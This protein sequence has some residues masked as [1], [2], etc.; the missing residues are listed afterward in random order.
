LPALRRAEQAGT[1]ILPAVQPAALDT[2]PLEAG[3]PPDS[4][5]EHTTLNLKPPEPRR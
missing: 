4:V 5:I 2:D 3:P 1:R